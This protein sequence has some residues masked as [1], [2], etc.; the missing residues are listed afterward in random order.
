LKIKEKILSDQNETI[1]TLRKRLS[2]EV[3]TKEFSLKNATLTRKTTKGKLAE[4]TER[5]TGVGN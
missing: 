4:R 3:R 5:K 1:S 2:D